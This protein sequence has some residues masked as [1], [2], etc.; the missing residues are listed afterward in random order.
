MRLVFDNLHNDKSP[1]KADKAAFPMFRGNPELCN[2]PC[3]CSWHLINSR[4]MRLKW[5]TL[6]HDVQLASPH[7]GPCS[8]F[9]AF[10][11]HPLLSP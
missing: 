9:V 7:V 2:K 6:S 8:P 3:Y 4:F 11:Y 1:C 5:R 10:P